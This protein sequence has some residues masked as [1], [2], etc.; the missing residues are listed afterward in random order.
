MV[1]VY[2]VRCVY[3]LYPLYVRVCNYV[4]KA[5]SV[6]RTCKYTKRLTCLVFASRGKKKKRADKDSGFL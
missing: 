4:T 6:M 1:I 2:I 5:S 3:S